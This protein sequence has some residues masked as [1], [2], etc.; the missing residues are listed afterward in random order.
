MCQNNKISTAFLL[1]RLL[2]AV[3]R[4]NAASVLGTIG[5]TEVNLFFCYLLI[6]IIIINKIIYI[7]GNT[8]SLLLMARI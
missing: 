8:L 4:G 6:P 1:Q 5:S 3:Q 2:I 7:H